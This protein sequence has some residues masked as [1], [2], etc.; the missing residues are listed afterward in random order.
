MHDKNVDPRSAEGSCLHIGR[1]VDDLGSPALTGRPTLP[2]IYYDSAPTTGQE[3]PGLFVGGRAALPLDV[4]HLILGFVM[5]PAS[6]PLQPRALRLPHPQHPTPEP[7]TTHTPSRATLD[8]QTH[9]DLDLPMDRRP[10]IGPSLVSSITRSTSAVRS[11]GSPCARS[12][13]GPGGSWP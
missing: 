10:Q 5:M 7:H 8:P 3:A 11:S 2:F 13:W 12:A 9:V 6:C 4:C 1:L